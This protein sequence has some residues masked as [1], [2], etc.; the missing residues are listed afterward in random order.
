MRDKTAFITLKTAVFAPIPRASVKTA[1]V[2]NPGLL[3]NWRS[4]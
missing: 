1:T 3:R 2:V 4:A